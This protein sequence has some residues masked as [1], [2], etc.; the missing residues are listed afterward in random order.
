MKMGI[1]DNIESEWE[2]RAKCIMDQ[3]WFQDEASCRLGIP[4]DV[5]GWENKVAQEIDSRLQERQANS[6]FCES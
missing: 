4:E 3:H 1:V 5:E 2:N 6:N